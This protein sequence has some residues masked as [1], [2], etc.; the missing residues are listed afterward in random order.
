MT[1]YDFVFQN[2]WKKKLQNACKLN[3]KFTL[4]LPVHLFFYNQ[5]I[6][7]PKDFL[8]LLS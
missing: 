1:F 4:F 7:Y 5:N 6:F 2:V 8:H 3:E